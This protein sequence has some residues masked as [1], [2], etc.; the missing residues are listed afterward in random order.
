MRIHPRTIALLL[1][2]GDPSAESLM[3]NYPGCGYFVRF[4]HRRDT[5][6]R[7]AS[8]DRDG[9]FVLWDVTTVNACG[10]TSYLAR[11]MDDNGRS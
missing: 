8:T 4:S 7:A 2:L 5:S 1:S 3:V 6:R 11:G 9:A 10:G